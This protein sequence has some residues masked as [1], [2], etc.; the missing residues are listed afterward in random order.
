MTAAFKDY[1]ISSLLNSAK[2]GI[3][4][5]SLH[6]YIYVSAF[7]LLAYLL[8]LT[9]DGVEGKTEDGERERETYMKA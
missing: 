8:W 4:F 6:T 1:R 2:T 5:L 9:L 3:I 7:Q